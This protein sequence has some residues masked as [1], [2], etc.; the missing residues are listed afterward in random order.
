MLAALQ[1]VKAVLEPL[2]YPVYLLGAE[3]PTDTEV[4]PVPYLVLEVAP[5]IGPLPDELPICGPTGDLQ[6]DMRVRAV[7]YPVDAA[8]KVL[9]RAR[10]VLAPNLGGSRVPAVGRVIDLEF[11]RAEFTALTDRDVTAAN[12]NRHPTSALDSYTVHAQAV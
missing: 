8:S 1:A 5:G 2:G 12:L 9:A 11:Q 6:F 4:P 10:V 7:G 3:G